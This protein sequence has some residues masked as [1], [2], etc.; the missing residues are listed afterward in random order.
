MPSSAFATTTTT[1]IAKDWPAFSDCVTNAGTT[2]PVEIDVTGNAQLPS[3]GYKIVSQNI[4]IVLLGDST[5]GGGMFTQPTDGNYDLTF[6]GPIT[7]PTRQ[8]FSGFLLTNPVII[9]GS[10]VTVLPEWF[11]A[12]GDDSGDDALALNLA[13]ASCGSIKGNGTYKISSTINV[14]L[15]K[16]S[17]SQ[18]CSSSSPSSFIYDFSGGEIH[19]NGSGYAF[20]IFVSQFS[21]GNPILQII[22]GHSTGSPTAAGFM[23]V[24]DVEAP[25][26]FGWK[27]DHYSNANAI[28]FYHRDWAG[29]S[30]NLTSW[31]NTC[32]GLQTCYQFDGGA[33]TVRLGPVGSEATDFA[34]TGVKEEELSLLLIESNAAIE[35]TRSLIRNLLTGEEYIPEVKVDRQPLPP[36]IIPPEEDA[37]AKKLKARL[38]KAAELLKQKRERLH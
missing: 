10:T 15:Y 27:L 26:I 35:C 11:G 37:E 16:L 33:D 17:P 30:E 21:G 2:N 20:D 34:L 36:T 1:C 25:F 24:T 32:L 9:A 29:W 13:V 14:D 28:G 8:I 31:K 22:G 19:N 6:K 23:R 18:K 3:T 4:S 12:K 5:N 38:N 7:A